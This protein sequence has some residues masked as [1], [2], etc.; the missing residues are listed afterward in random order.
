MFSDRNTYDRISGKED[1]STSV[2]LQIGLTQFTPGV[3]AKDSEVSCKCTPGRTAFAV[4]AKK[5]QRE[6]GDANPY[7]K[8]LVVCYFNNSVIVVLLITDI[9]VCLS[10][11]S[12]P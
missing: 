9:H 6:H 11:E 8:C 5:L 4:K 10:L 12:L 7:L 2:D 1:Y 3:N